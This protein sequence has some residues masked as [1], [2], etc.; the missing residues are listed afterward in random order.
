MGG[1][2]GTGHANVRRETVPGPRGQSLAAEWDWLSRKDS[3]VWSSRMWG[4]RLESEVNG[5][6][7]DRVWAPRSPAEST[8]EGG[9]SRPPFR[10]RDK[11]SSCGMHGRQGRWWESFEFGF[12]WNNVPEDVV[13]AEWAEEVQ[14]VTPGHA[15]LMLPWMTTPWRVPSGTRSEAGARRTRGTQWLHEK[16]EAQTVTQPSPQNV[17]SSWHADYILISRYLS[18]KSNNKK[19]QK[20]FTSWNIKMHL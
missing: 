4:Q 2:R 1:N 11:G 8:E 17:S 20:S 6:R 19:E 7:Q 13:N 10:N 18:E 9:A 5:Q 14:V 12:V 3:R 16:E 15:A